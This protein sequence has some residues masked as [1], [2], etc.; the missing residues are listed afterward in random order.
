MGATGRSFRETF[1]S[2]K[3]TLNP[4]PSSSE[5]EEE[6]VEDDEALGYFS[7]IPR[8]E[9]EGPQPTWIPDHPWLYFPAQS[10]EL[11]Q[12]QMYGRLHI[13]HHRKYDVIH[14]LSQTCA[15]TTAL[16]CRVEEYLNYTV[17]DHR[18][19]HP[20]RDPTFGDPIRLEFPISQVLVLEFFATLEVDVFSTDYASD[21][22][23]I[24]A[25]VLF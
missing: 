3:K 1:L 24:I 21:D 2:K 17:R 11:S 18:N 23:I 15:L 14:S 20:F 9:V 10:G 22:Y 8:V 4:K 13:Y 16:V 19:R 5:Y 25:F 7:D 6:Q 12:A